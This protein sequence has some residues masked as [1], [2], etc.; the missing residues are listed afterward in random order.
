MIE[1]AIREVKSIPSYLQ[2]NKF[3]TDFLNGN[4]YYY[5][6]TDIGK[7]DI[8]EIT[9][10]VLRETAIILAKVVGKYQIESGIEAYWRNIYRMPSKDWDDSKPFNQ[11]TQ[12]MMIDADDTQDC[13]EGCY[14]LISIQINNIGDYVEDFKFHHF[15]ILTRIFSD[16]KTYIDVPKII[17]QVDENII[18]NINISKIERIDEFYEIWLPHDSDIVEFDWQSLAGLYKDY[19]K[20]LKNKDKLLADKD[21]IIK[22]LKKNLR[23]SNSFSS[24]NTQLTKEV[25]RITKIITEK[26]SKIKDY[27]KDI[28][29]KDLLLANKDKALKDLE[30]KLKNANN[31]I[32]EKD[33][34]IK[35]LE[36]N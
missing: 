6:Y 11:F 4:K 30:N 15:S 10:N 25:T 8:C 31:S 34:I 5:L 7:N 24:E 12:K 28:R 22:D 26:D 16:N 29:N 17:I 35:D 21:K 23:D 14:L 1:V 19:E 32:I 3:K 18:G 2:K 20:D 33:K 36:K 13:I 27:E 9:V